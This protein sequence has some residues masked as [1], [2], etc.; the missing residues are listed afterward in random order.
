[1][2]AQGVY[3]LDSPPPGKAWGDSLLTED[4]YTAREEGRVCGTLAPATSPL[5]SDKTDMDAVP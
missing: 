4:P 3:P 1:M 5:R 2:A